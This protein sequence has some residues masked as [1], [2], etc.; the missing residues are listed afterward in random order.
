MSDQMLLHRNESSEQKTLNFKG[1]SQTR[2]TITFYQEELQDLQVNDTDLHHPLKSL[3][4]DK[5]SLLMIEKLKA[6]P[7][8]IPSPNQDE[9]MLMLQSVFNETISKID[10]HFAFK[11]N[12]LTIKLDGSED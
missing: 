9:I 8:K 2:R 11:R 12:G 7:E 5:E 3:Y 1:S 6:N 10:I 4:H